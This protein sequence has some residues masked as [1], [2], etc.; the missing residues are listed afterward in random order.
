MAFARI[1]SGIVHWRETGPRQAPAV[2]LA[3]SLGTDLRLWDEVAEQLSRNWRVIVY[4]KRG[5]GLSEVP[6]GPYTIDGFTDDLIGLADHVG[7]ARF[8]LVGLSIGG[9]IAQNVAIRHPERLTALVLADTA[10]KIGTAESWA[11]RIETVRKH[12]LAAIADPVMERW[13]TPS[14]HE[15]R[16]VDLAGW[17]NLFQRQPA[18]GY[19]ATCEALRDAD[20]TDA[21]GTIS[22]PTLV[23]CGDGD[24]STPPELVRAAA[25]RIP[26]ARFATIEGCG[27]IPPAEQPRALLALLEAHLAEH[28]R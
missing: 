18:D 20:L 15:K 7:L 13:F 21:I 8:A 1:D 10:P 26:G 23:V 16:A 4:D 12:G 14:F 2:I 3:N 6:A 17:R 25:E 11:A 24:L 27:H 28:A 22:A 9:L 5:H 19:A